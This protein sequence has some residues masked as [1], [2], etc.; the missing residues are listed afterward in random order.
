MHLFGMGD[1]AWRLF[2]F[3]LMGAATASFFAITRRAGD[4]SHN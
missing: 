2:D 4:P 1:L 3:A